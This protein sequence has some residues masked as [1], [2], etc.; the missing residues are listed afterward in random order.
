MAVMTS[1]GSTLSIATGSPATYD[2]AGFTALTYVIV[3]EVTDIGEVTNREYAVVNHMPVGS[4]TVKKFKGS[5]QTGTLQIQMAR[6]SSNA[7]QTALRAALVSDADY[8][9]KVTLQD[10]SKIHFVGKVTAFKTSV[11]SVDQITGANCTVELS[12]DV[13]EI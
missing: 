4:R 5:Y 9:F 3:G 8:S 1:A 10:L 2:A 12:G 11:G 13:V 6:D 7:G